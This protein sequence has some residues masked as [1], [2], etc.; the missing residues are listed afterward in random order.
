MN[1]LPW[2]LIWTFVII[3]MILNDLGH[4]TQ[5]PLIMYNLYQILLISAE[6]AGKARVVAWTP[7][8]KQQC[9]LLL[10][11]KLWTTFI[12]CLNGERLESIKEPTYA[13]STWVIALCLKKSMS[14]RVLCFHRSQS[15]LEPIDTHESFDMG[16]D[17]NWPIHIKDKRQMLVGFSGF[18][19]QSERDISLVEWDQLCFVFFSPTNYPWLGMKHTHRG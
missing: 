19:V 15:E 7:L 4:S 14:T 1:G 10:T 11:F 13:T 12:R 2:D 9:Y 5:E 17:A 16:V 6:A 18:F 3:R 8:T